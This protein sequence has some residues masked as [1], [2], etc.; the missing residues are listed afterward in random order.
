MK[1]I[2]LIVDPQNDFCT[3]KKNESFVKYVREDV[4]DKK[5]DELNNQL[6]RAQKGVDNLSEY[7]SIKI[8]LMSGTL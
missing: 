7:L 5:I 6:R 4:V 8:M 2:L 3:Y 1:Q